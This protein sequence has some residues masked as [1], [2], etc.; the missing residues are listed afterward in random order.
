MAVS[1]LNKR[2]HP[3]QFTDV[4]ILGLANIVTASV[5]VFT[6]LY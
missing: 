1:A 2:L 5:V 4:L 3:N 6:D